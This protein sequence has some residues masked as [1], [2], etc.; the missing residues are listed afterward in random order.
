M[1]KLLDNKLDNIFSKILDNFYDFL[2]KRKIIDKINQ[3]E[4][5]VTFQNLIID[6]IKNF[7]E[8][9]QKENQV[10]FNSI[11]DSKKEKNNQNQNSQ[12]K[13]F[14]DFIVKYY[15]YYIF[16]SIAYFYQSG[17]DLFTTN[18]IEIIKNKK[19]NVFKIENFFNS[20]NN[21]K[22]IYIFNI[23]KNFQN[24]NKLANN[25]EKIKIILKNNPIKFES[26]IT[27]FEKI[28]EEFITKNL[29]IRDNTHN[30][31]KSLIMNE[32]YNEEKEEIIKKM[33][34][35]KESLT[36]YKFID[37]VRSKD[38]K[39]IDFILLQ[40]YLSIKQINSGL[41]T[42]IYS[43]LQE[44]KIKKDLDVKT[45]KQIVN[46]LFNSKILIPITEDFLRFHKD[47]EKYT[48]QSMIDDPASVVSQKEDTKI[49]LLLNKIQKITNLNSAFNEKNQ[50]VKQD[51]EKLFFQQM[52]DRLI[53]TYNENEELK[54]IQKLE[55]SEKISDTD[56]VNELE[57]FRNYAYLN[58]RDLSKDGFNFRPSETTKC[59]R[60][61]NI[62]FKNKN[63]NQKLEYRIGNDSV[64]VNIVGVAWNPSALSLDH[65]TK[66]DL[67]DV[68]DVMNDN[69]GI[70]S[71]ESVI[72][73]TFSN[74]K[75]KLFYW[76]FDNEKDKLD[77]KEYV[78]VDGIEESTKIMINIR[79]IF[80]LY[81]ELLENKIKSE[82][83]NYSNISIYDIINITNYYG[84][85]FFDFKF[86]DKI[87]KNVFNFG[88]NTKI[89]DKKII[90]DETDSFIPG[91]GKDIIRLPDVTDY[92]LENFTKLKKRQ[93][94]LLVT[95]RVEEDI[96]LEEEKERPICY[97][98]YKIRELSRLSKNRSEDFNQNVFNFVK[99]Y[100]KT[101]DKNDYICRS[102]EEHL[103]LTKFETT[104]T[105]VPELD[106][107]LTT[108]LGVKEDL[109]KIPKYAK[110]SRGIRNIEKNLEKISFSINLSA[111]LGG[112]PIQ[113][114]RRRTIIKDV[115]DMI[116]NHTEFL[117]DEPKNRMEIA[118][119]EFGISISNLFF[120][121]F[122]DDIFLTSSQDTDKFK[123][124]KYNNVLS[125]MILMIISEINVGQ[126]LGLKTDKRCNFYVYNNIKNN[127]FN[128]IKIRL[129]EDNSKSILE[130]PILC[131]ILY[132]FSCVFTSNYF[133]LW[134]YENDKGFN[135][136]IQITIINTIVDLFNTII[137]ANFKLKDK[138]FQYEII[139]NRILDKVGKLYKDEDLMKSIEDQFKSKI[140]VDKE[141]NK[142]SF[143]TKRIKMINI[144]DK[145]TNKS[146]E[147]NNEELK[148]KLIK[149]S[150]V[151]DS[152]ANEIPLVESK[153]RKKYE[154]PQYITNCSDGKFHDWVYL[155]EGEKRFNK[156]DLV[157]TKCKKK[158][159]EVSKFLSGNSNSISKEMISQYEKILNQIKINN[160]SKL[161]K[162]HCLDGQNHEFENEGNKCSKCGINP[163][164]FNYTSKDYFTLEENLKKMDNLKIKNLLEETKKLEEKIKIDFQKKSQILDKFKQ[165][166]EGHTKLNIIKYVEDFSQRL[167]SILGKSIK[168]G[169]TEIFIDSTY[170]VI[171]HDN[172]GNQ[173]K[174]EIIIFEKDNKIFYEENHSYFKK[175]IYYFKDNKKNMKIY[176][177]AINLNYLG[178][179]DAGSSKITE[180]KTYS[181]LNIISSI[182]DK[183]LN[184]GLPDYYFN[185]NLLNKKAEDGNIS[186]KEIKELIL[187]MIIFRSQNIKE[188]INKFIRTIYSVK[189]RKKDFS[190]YA[191]KEI[192]IINE[193]IN[194]I[195]KFETKD[196]NNSKSVF[197]H[198]KYIMNYPLDKLITNNENYNFNKNLG[199]DFINSDVLFPLNN[200][201]SKFLFFLIH[202]L[203]RLL[204][205]NS[206]SQQINQNL[207]FMIVKLINYNF[208]FY[209]IPFDNIALRKFYKIVNINAPNIDES[210]RVVGSYEELLN[211]QEIDDE[212]KG[213]VNKDSKDDDIYYNK[214][215][216][217][218]N[219]E[220]DNR[221][222]KDA[223]DI[224]DYEN[225]D[226]E[227]G[228]GEEETGHM[229][230]L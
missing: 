81:S 185:L 65:F 56:M 72:R 226:D 199:F 39:L 143:V 45:N 73:E 92:E 187:S 15:A 124:I 225:P 207:A 203:N 70:K 173:I 138:P 200:L 195:K 174:N 29:L 14:N 125:Y 206:N 149:I 84:Y 198:W 6:T 31:I 62:L 217:E 40:K 30:L 104:G 208:D 107:F 213:L 189:H 43:F 57:N 59:L 8:Y 105:Y 156:V 141:S 64:D 209:R 147:N 33:S 10:F 196:D 182:K 192:K 205:Y 188:I 86:D 75:E 148:T 108:S 139:V 152:V 91:R 22:I 168:L 126:I 83:G 9:S 166:Y 154:I 4:N 116:L 94:T 67:V 169:Q 184:L 26:T 98:H 191:Q 47:S 35:D 78:N 211:S 153:D 178:Y 165:R 172:Y 60:Y 224:D 110:F 69:N 44:M 186:S 88:F 190:I 25:I 204:D 197:K 61:T 11:F 37:V 58:F 158:Y 128:N 115:I 221:E 176:Y 146:D 77:M 201:D 112:T 28:G 130:Y 93:T 222:E 160:L 230:F 161:V 216:E 102:C 53:V 218:K 140:K 210:L 181:K 36:K 51:T 171:D 113:R 170:Y 120:F 150:Q 95:D 13:F 38:S 106:V 27:Y 219:K 99:Q 24:V 96:S 193:S 127:L 50:K 41:A 21:S 177:D 123:K 87:Q 229:D 42:E 12:Y 34:D 220:D 54:I 80:F 131:Y 117:K 202:N 145:I 157:C 133:W 159:S 144:D 55:D 132:Y 52:I 155:K 5:F 119:K 3:D 63:Q 101:N 89:L 85:K 18:I 179:S 162:E 109:W 76:L 74:S 163:D 48:Y 214:T 134:D 137:E 227:D 122:E 167:K 19:N 121:K 212:N 68:N 66:N 103:N 164:T 82:I 2:K 151:C 215:D 223:V 17:R 49:K 1:I 46:F 135:S 79:K 118:S 136:T 111:Y 183:L 114:L 129:G 97:H 71:F 20:E 90:P 142:V 32:I 16:F 180:I 175:D 228:Y 7:N 23:I 194:N 100:V